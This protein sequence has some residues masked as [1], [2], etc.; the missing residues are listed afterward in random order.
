MK[1]GVAI[2]NHEEGCF[3]A[4]RDLPSIVEEL[5]FHSLWLTDHVVG[6][7]DYQNYG[8]IW[9]ECLTSLSYVAGRTSTVRLGLGVLV[10]PYRHPVYLAKM[11]ATIDHLSGGRLDVGVGVG[12]AK[13]E[14]EALGCGPLYRTRGKVTDE[15]LRV[16]LSLWDEGTIEIPGDDGSAVVG[17]MRPAPVQT[18]HPPLFVGGDSEAALRRAARFADVW[19]PVNIEASRFAV[20]ADQLDERAGRAVRRSV[21]LRAHRDELSKLDDEL[22][23]FADAGCEL[24]VVE[25]LPTEAA[26]LHDSLERIASHIS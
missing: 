20:V 18:P 12:W 23:A 6:V 24:A 16:M 13:S 5:G 9:A 3:E 19:H 2:P 22:A 10:V 14:F 7:A 11:L 26:A 17:T 21:R 4:L 15:S 8:D 25:V 1:L